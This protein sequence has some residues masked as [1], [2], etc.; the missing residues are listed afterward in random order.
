MNL[1]VGQMVLKKDVL[2]P[3]P[4]RAKSILSFEDWLLLEENAGQV[5]RKVRLAGW[6]F[7]WLTHAWDGWS[8]AFNAQRS[9]EKALIKALRK[10]DR[11][12]HAA[13][14]TTIKCYRLLG[15]RFCKVLVEARHI[16][17]GPILGLTEPVGMMNR[18]SGN[19]ETEKRLP[20]AA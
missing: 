4:L 6:H 1:F 10:I 12:F 3:E 5:E 7:F 18:S 9:L 15:L 20:S 16:Q 14:I 13:E 17:H 11:R 8:M 19:T 2:L